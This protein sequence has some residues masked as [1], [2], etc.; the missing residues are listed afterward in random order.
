MVKNVTDLNVPKEYDTYYMQKFT[1]LSVPDQLSCNP[2]GTGGA[3]RWLNTVV[4]SMAEPTR[5]WITCKTVVVLHPSFYTL[6]SN[7]IVQQT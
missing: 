2:T 4:Q 7:K 5:L 1:V 3:W 6:P